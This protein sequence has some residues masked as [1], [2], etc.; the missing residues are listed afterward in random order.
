MHVN[1]GIKRFFNDLVWYTRLM[2]S[3]R[4]VGK[5]V[6]QRGMRGAVNLVFGPTE[7]HVW[8]CLFGEKGFR[9]HRGRHVQ[10]LG[11]VT[12][13]QDIVLKMLAG[14]TS[15]YTAEMTGKVRVEGEGQSAWVISST[16][17]Q[18][19]SAARGGGLRGWFSRWH[20]R[21]ILRRSGTGYELQL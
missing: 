7:H 10:P 15:Y 14:L 5:Q 6:D 21:S 3:R 8:H 19:L 1:P 11:T 13:D 18:A 16:V 4:L 2:G 9:F 17:M 12:V 20:L